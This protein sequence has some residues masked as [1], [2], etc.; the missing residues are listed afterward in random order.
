MPD[1]PGPMVRRRQLGGAL[2]RYR[3][4]AGLTVAEAA[5]RLLVAPSKISRIETAQRN[6]TIRDV[7]DLCEIYG[8][9]DPAVRD[10]LMELARG[11][12]ER[13]WWQESGLSPGM[14]NLIGQEGAAET[15]KEF[16]PL[17][18]PGLLQTRE[19]AAAITSAYVSPGDDDFVRR[20]VETRMR[21]QQLLDDDNS[22]ELV[23]VLDE[24][25][26][27]RIIGGPAIMRRQ[28]DHLIERAQHP[29]LT[30]RVIPFAA[31]AHVGLNG[32]FTILEFPPLD[33]DGSAH[34]L[35]STVYIENLHEYTFRLQLEDVDRYR[36]AFASL[37]SA[38]AE[39]QKTLALLKAAGAT[40]R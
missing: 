2:R 34:D 37:T 19:Y 25:V 13:A 30:I 40:M 26:L 20:V 35:A 18:V 27:H 9:D 21:R 36:S 29:R 6:A 16:E 31:G 12:R 15:I 32:G 4:A 5:T 17:S 1:N 8:I 3:S 23:V 24:A 28:I 38:S 39:P 10:H 7:R 14:Q 33:A 22:P 11:S